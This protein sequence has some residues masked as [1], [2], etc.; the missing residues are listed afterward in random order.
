MGKT[1]RVH[2]RIEGLVQGV[3]FRS[4]IKRRALTLG[5]KGWVKNLWDG[6][7][8]AVFEGKEEDVERLLEFCHTGPPGARVENVDVTYSSY[9]GEFQDF[10][11]RY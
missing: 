3:F 7:V 4:N 6:S 11:I 10:A 8:E 1:V 5:V 2:V 9:K